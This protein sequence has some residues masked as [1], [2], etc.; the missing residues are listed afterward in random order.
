[1]SL[2][3]DEHR[4]YLED[5]HRVDAFRRAIAHAV[6]PGDVVLDLAS[7]TGILGMLACQAGAARVYALEQTGL[8][9]LAR[10][11]AA[12]NGFADRITVI[13]EHSMRASLPELVDCIV[14]DQIGHFGFEAGLFEYTDD[15]CRWLK[16]GGRVVPHTLQLW[17]APV[18]SAD[19]RGRLAF[20]TTHPGA[21]D[22]TPA[23]PIARNTGYPIALDPSALVADARRLLSLDLPTSASDWLS[24]EL[25][26]VVARGGMLDGVAG[27][28]LA[29]LAPGV[30]LTNQPGHPNRIQRRHVVLPTTQPIAVSSGD[31]VDVAVRIRPVDTIVNWAITVKRSGAEPIVAARAS[32]FAGFLLS[33]EDLSRTPD[34][35]PRLTRAGQARRALLV[36]IDGDHTVGQIEDELQRDF[37]DLFPNRDRVAEFVAEV[38]SG[39]AR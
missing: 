9:G 22:Y 5:A 37:S 14:C 16:P 32:T 19:V 38:L 10:E 3:L 33:S 35:R 6:R 12:V 29:D 27:W 24:A 15:A 17:M 18:E 23:A 28:F 7:G 4:E 11:I 13:R 26:F 31:R 2:V 20:W 39:Y 30:T 25:D 36:L 21:L 8:A 34:A 1:M